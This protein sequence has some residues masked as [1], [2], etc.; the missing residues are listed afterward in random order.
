M[1]ESKELGEYLLLTGMKLR[2]SWGRH[3]M[4]R[5]LIERQTF[6][7]YRL[8]NKCIQ[9]FDG[10]ELS[11]SDHLE[12]QEGSGRTIFRYVQFKERGCED[13]CNSRM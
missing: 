4:N 12:N 3:L 11:G 2:G 6:S 5:F 9:N 10:G 8:E 13:G 7:S 1:F